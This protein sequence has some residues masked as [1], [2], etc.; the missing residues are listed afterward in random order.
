LAI[1]EIGGVIL[2]LSYLLQK[3]SGKSELEREITA[4]LEKCKDPNKKI[5][6]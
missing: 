3:V 1:A 6:F 2:P 4:Q 5:C